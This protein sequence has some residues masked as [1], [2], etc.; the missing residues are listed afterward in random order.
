MWV[1][2]YIKALYKDWISLMSGIA[3]VTLAVWVVFF[4]PPDIYASRTLL[5]IATIACLLLANYRV[6][7]KEHQAC[8]D[9]DTKQK[10]LR[11]REELLPLLQEGRRLARETT[12][13]PPTLNTTGQLEAEERYWNERRAWMRETTNFLRI[14][15][16]EPYFDRF[17]S[18]NKYRG[19]ISRSDIHEQVF[20]LEIVARELLE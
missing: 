1:W 10:R 14:Y 4:P 2:E 11:I 6:W 8:V 17:H 3:S 20:Q 16:G 9:S 18:H 5:W 7:S 15:L 12:D 13:E 19:K